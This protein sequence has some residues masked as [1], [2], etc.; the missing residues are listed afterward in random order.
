M[1]LLQDLSVIDS[2]SIFLVYVV[3]LGSTTKHLVLHLT[4]IILAVITEAKKKTASAWRWEVRV[5]EGGQD[6]GQ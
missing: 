5:L 1:C 2:I 4:D 3:E 6:G